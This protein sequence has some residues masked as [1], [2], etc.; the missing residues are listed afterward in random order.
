VRVVLLGPPGVGKGTQGRRLAADRGWA[1]ISTGELLRDAVA[2][3][4]PL[5]LEAQQIMDGG[6]LVSDVLMIE[7][8]R[9]RTAAPDAATGFVLDGFPR[10]VPQAAALDALLTERG[11]AVDVVLALKVP[12]DDLVER[13]TARRECPVCKRSYNLVSAPPR[14]DNR[15]DDHP[16]AALIQ[17]V[18][19]VETTIRRR[20]DVYRAQTEPLVEYY[21][22]R[23][24]LAEVSGT[25]ATD[26]VYDRLRLALGA[27]V[28]GR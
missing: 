13:L 21:R 18:D 11:R 28:G 20:L 24:R 17:R 8:V 1:L 6:H 7:L 12:E 26:E 3:R 10:T 27:A 4:T 22:S 14:N 25:G 5:G 16:E 2:R 15:C 9:E 19:D 23:G